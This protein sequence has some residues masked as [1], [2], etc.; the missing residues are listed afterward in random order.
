MTV[1]QGIAQLEVNQRSS[2]LIEQ[3]DN[4]LY[5]AKAQ[6]RNQFYAQATS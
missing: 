5:L 4:H 2:Q 3:A 1:S 6:G